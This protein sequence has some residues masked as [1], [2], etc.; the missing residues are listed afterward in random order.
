M[1]NRLASS[2]IWKFSN[3]PAFHRECQY[4]RFRSDSKQFERKLK[5]ISSTEGREMM[6]EPRRQIPSIPMESVSVILAAYI[7]TGV[8][9]DDI[10]KDRAPQTPFEEYLCQSIMLRGPLSVAAFMREALMNPKYGYYLRKDKPVFGTHGDFI[11]SPEISQLFGELI[12]VWFVAV[13]EKMSEKEKEEFII[14]ECGPGKGTLMNDLLRV[15]RRFPNF[16]KGI[17]SVHLV[18]VSHA[19]RQEQ[20]KRLGVSSDVKRG[21]EGEMKSGKTED[22]TTIH[23]HN[24][25]TSV[26][27][28][29][30]LLVAQEFFDCLSVHQFEYTATGWCERMVDVNTGEGQHHLRMVLSPTPTLSAMTL[31]RSQ[32]H[33]GRYYQQEAKQKIVKDEQEDQEHPVHAASRQ[34]DLTSAPVGDKQGEIGQCVEMCPD[35]ITLS[36]DISLRVAKYGGAALI[37][38]YGQDGMTP[39]T[40]R[41]IKDHKFVDLL[42]S[43][44]QTDLS[45]LVDFASLKRAAGA[46][47]NVNT[48][49][50]IP[51]GQW[52]ISMGIETRAQRLVDASTDEQESE[53][54][55]SAYER[56]VSPEQMGQSYKVISFANRSL[57]DVPGF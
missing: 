24:N 56:L 31:M 57:G 37:I 6:H 8:E 55:A 17:K 47:E 43:P 35:G 30:M 22:G 21:K 29:P 40:L 34:I 26:P 11:T 16:K 54:I 32:E 27:R 5:H 15:S 14:V 49:G 36:M 10:S 28:S 41:A 44:G 18:E 48:F 19:L 51:Q 1:I 12:G 45:A 9:L 52:L 23:W 33:M 39:D 13:W 4:V 42:E 25:F 20:A 53:A 7:L 46:I 3:S 50:A 38:D 2:S